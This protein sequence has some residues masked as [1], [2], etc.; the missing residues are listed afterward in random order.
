MNLYE[1]IMPLYPNLTS[2]DFGAG[3]TMY[4]KILSSQVAFNVKVHYDHR[5]HDR[6]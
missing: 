5:N 4:A 1:Q 2:A 3:G 6:T